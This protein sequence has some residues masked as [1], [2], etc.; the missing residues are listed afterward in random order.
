MTVLDHYAECFAPAPGRC[1]RLVCRPDAE[2]QP[3]HCPA[4]WCSWD[5]PVPAATVY[6]KPAFVMNGTGGPVFTG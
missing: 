5:L 2:G 3:I 1:F 4:P 6:L